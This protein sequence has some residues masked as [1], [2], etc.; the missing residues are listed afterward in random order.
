MPEYGIGIIS[1]SNLTYAS[2]GNINAKVMDNVVRLAKLQPRQL[3]V[4]PIL[5]QRKNELTALLPGWENPEKAGI[6]AE[7]FFMD[8]FT[9]SLKKEA[10]AIFKNAGKIIRVHDFTPLNNL[11]GFFVL[12]GEKSNIEIEFTLTPENPPLIQEYY[13]EGKAKVD[14]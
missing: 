6:F 3:P 12:E 10:S 8:Y 14:K 13:I 5:N 9:D 11:R 4:S 1:F 7:N 2:A